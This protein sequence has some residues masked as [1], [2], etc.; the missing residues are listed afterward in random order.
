M[1]LPTHVQRRNSPDPFVELQHEFDTVLNRFFGGT[2]PQTTTGRRSAPYAVDV[3]EDANHMYFE[4]ELPGFK[5]HEVDITL[6]NST[7]TIT[8]ERGEGRQAGG[9][10]QAGSVRSGRQSPPEQNGRRE[11]L[12][13]ERRYTYFC[14]SFTLPPTVSTENVSA[15]IEDGVLLLTLSKR[16]EAKPR[17]IEVK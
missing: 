8:A 3:H 11:T 9:D 5:R 7:L 17:K 1:T 12:L 4:V 10:G 16:E 6:D 2:S 14:R 15:R 13:N